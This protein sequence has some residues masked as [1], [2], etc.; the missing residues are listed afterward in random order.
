[1]VAAV[2]GSGRQWFAGADGGNGW[3]SFGGVLKYLFLV[4]IV[5]PGFLEAAQ[6]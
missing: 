4:G 2:N 3:K 5:L 1:M 6:R